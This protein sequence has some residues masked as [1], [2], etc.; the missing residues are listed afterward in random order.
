[1][2]HRGLEVLSIGISTLMALNPLSL[3]RAEE[4]NSAGEKTAGRAQFLQAHERAR[5]EARLRHDQLF[6]EPRLSAEELRTL[7]QQKIK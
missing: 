3:V 7:I 1:M 4:R 2:A 6:P 5:N